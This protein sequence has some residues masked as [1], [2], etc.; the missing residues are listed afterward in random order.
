MWVFEKRGIRN[1]AS[2]QAATSAF[3]DDLIRTD[4]RV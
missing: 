4:L 2:K 3:D 1:K